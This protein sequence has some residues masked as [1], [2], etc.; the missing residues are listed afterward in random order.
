MHVMGLLGKTRFVAECGT[1][2]GVGEPQLEWCPLFENVGH[3]S[4][5]IKESAKAD[6]EYRIRELGMFA[7]KRRF[8]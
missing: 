5:L 4:R 1:V 6:M 2:V 3:A 7:P 8:D